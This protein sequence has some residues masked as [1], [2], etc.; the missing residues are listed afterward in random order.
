MFRR[1]LLISFAVFLADRVTK[2]LAVRFLSDVPT[3]PLIPGVFH[4]TLVRNTGVAFGLFQGQGLL[5]MLGA[6]SFVLGL[7][8]TVLKD[9]PARGFLISLALVLGGALGNLLD[10]LRFGSVI[11]FLDLRLWPV[12]NLADSCITIGVAWM[13]W[14]ML[15]RR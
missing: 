8:W 7:V 12:F 15:R 13:A 1:L 4:L 11:D 9:K 6:L 14:Q 2:G 3:L 5:I 10:R